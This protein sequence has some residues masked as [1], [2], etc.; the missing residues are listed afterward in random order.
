MM[1]ILQPLLNA[2]STNTDSKTKTKFYITVFIIGALFV[3]LTRR[4]NWVVTPSIDATLLRFTDE[5]F[6]AGDY[7]TFSL[8]HP[9]ANHGNGIAVTKK[10]VCLPGDTLKIVRG[11]DFFCNGRFIGKAYTY[12]ADI[13]KALPVFTF[14]GIIP[15][16]KGFVTGNHPKSFDSRNWGFITLSES[17]NNQ[18][19]L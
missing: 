8:K 15:D 16:N 5:P 11:V 14:Q 7:V 10:L 9:L 19:I 4:I 17:K 18:V 6:K 13:K 1:K 12:S 3:F 2:T